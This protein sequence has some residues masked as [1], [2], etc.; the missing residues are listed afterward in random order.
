VSQALYEGKQDRI[1]GADHDEPLDALVKMTKP[2]ADQEQE[3]DQEQREDAAREM[4]VPRNPFDRKDFVLFMIPA[5]VIV[6]VMLEGS[7][8]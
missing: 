8:Q 3:V 4:N 7:S 6:F 2:F 5:V 1:Q